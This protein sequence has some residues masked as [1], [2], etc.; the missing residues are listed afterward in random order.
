MSIKTDAAKILKEMEQLHARLVRAMKRLDAEGY[1]YQADQVSRLAHFGVY[2]AMQKLKQVAD[3]EAPAVV[4]LDDLS[5][6]AEE[7]L[8]WEATD[9]IEVAQE[10]FDLGLLENFTEVAESESIDL[11]LNDLGK[12]LQ[13]VVMSQG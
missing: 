1:G 11:Y 3:Y 9:D 4:L 12:Q 8:R 13:S 6:E 5:A 2:E 10:L 7:G